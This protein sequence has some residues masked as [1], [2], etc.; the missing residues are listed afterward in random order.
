MTT[1]LLALSEIAEG[2]ASQAAL[3]NTALREL[4]SRSIRVLSRTTTAPPGSPAES[5]AYIIPAGATG[6]WSGK[7]NQIASWIGGAWSYYPP[8]EGVIVWI[9]DTNNT[10]AYDGAA[11]GLNSGS[12]SGTVTN[13]AGNLTS[14]A[15]VLGAGTTDTKVVAGVITDGVSTLTLGVAGTSVGSVA[16][17]NATSGT[18]TVSPP[19]G[20]LGTVTL[21]LPAATDTLV[22]KAT[23]DTLTNKTLTAPVLGTP[24]SGTLT[25][26]TGL[27]VA[28]GGTGVASLTAYAP[29]FGGTTTTAAVQSGAVGTTGQVLT[30][31][32]AGALPTFQAAGG[33]SGGAI[34]YISYTFFGGL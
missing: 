16:L 1:P 25:N 8:V 15:V 30:S 10:Y 19:T 33:G 22:G 21:T 27:P 14:N 3:H 7:T 2:V 17:K 32:G 4:E 34:D 11:W 13:T 28:G 6:V 23:T 12:G 26:C 18:L 29:V 31:N 24:T 20:A 5:D 9:N